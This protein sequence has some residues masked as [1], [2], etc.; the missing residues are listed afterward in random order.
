MFNASIHKPVAPDS[1]RQ[2][3]D[4]PLR[5]AR[6]RAVG[7]IMF[8]AGPAGFAKSSGDDFH[9]QFEM[10][11]EQLADADF[12]MGNLEGTVGRYGD[13]PYSGYPRFNAP[14]TALA[15]LSDKASGAIF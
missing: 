13:I 1:C 14:D 7:D 6:I 3:G 4:S 12:T 5:H 11:S 15:P 8:C 2:S 9:D 10:I